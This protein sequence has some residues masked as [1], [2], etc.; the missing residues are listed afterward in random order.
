[1]RATTEYFCLLEF[2]T[3]IHCDFGFTELPKCQF[4]PKDFFFFAQEHLLEIK[5]DPDLTLSK[6]KF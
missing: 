5:Y 3:W 6:V 4:T 2:D 1:M